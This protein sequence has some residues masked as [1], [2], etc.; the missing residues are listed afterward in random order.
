MEEIII[1]HAV[2]A[3]V[4]AITEIYNYEVLNG[5]ATFDL[6]P[7][8]VEDRLQWFRETEHPH[9][10]I[11]AEQAGEVVGWGCLRAF[12]ERAAY[13]FTAQNSVYVHQ[14]HRG[15]GIGKLILASLIAEGR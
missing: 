3:D 6:E 4:P 15:R 12:H 7:K 8:S 9:C 11:V 13:R 1:R 14:G 5:W 10:I 2:E